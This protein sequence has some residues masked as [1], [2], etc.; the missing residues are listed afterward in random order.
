MDSKYGMQ[1]LLPAF[2][3]GKYNFIEK[4]GVSPFAGF[5]TGVRVGISDE[6]FYTCWSGHRPVLTACRL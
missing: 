6:A 4:K 2:I 5:R 1:V 3:D